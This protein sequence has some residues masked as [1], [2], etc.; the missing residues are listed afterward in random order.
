MRRLALVLVSLLLPLVLAELYYRCATP[1][2]HVLLL[3]SSWEENLTDEL[4]ALAPGEGDRTI[5]TFERGEAVQLTVRPR[6]PRFYQGDS[7]LTKRL[8]PGVKARMVTRDQDGDVFDSRVSIDSSGRRTGRVRG[9]PTLLFFGGSFCFGLGVNDDQTLPEQTAATM[10]ATAWNHGVG[11]YGT[12]QVLYLLENLPLEGVPEGRRQ[13]IYVSIPDHVRRAMGYLSCFR[14]T[15]GWA[16]YYQRSS[17]GRAVLQGTWLSQNPW[18]ARLYKVLVRS[19]L[20]KRLDWDV[21]LAVGEDD[22]A[23]VV[24]MVEECQ[25]LAQ[26]RW[27]AE[28]V[29][30]AYHDVKEESDLGERFVK[31]LR[32]RGIPVVESGVVKA[33]P[34]DGHPTAEGH[35]DAA[36]ILSDY[37]SRP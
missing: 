18:T 15:K 1:D 7:M 36:R 20:L 23:T 24:A 11:G 27:N 33:I 16:P 19:Y 34:K 10:G 26:E 21:P 37:L 12:H 4:L 2:S 5:M 32:E 8:I 13:V 6:G 31:G 35:R 17:Q 3:T 30:F 14:R 22:L 25:R 29:V 28:F 9:E